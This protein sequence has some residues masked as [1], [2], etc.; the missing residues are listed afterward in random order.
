MREETVDVRDH[1]KTPPQ[2]ETH[3][4]LTV[5]SCTPRT[6]THARIHT[7]N[8]SMKKHPALQSDAHKLYSSHQTNVAADA[9]HVSLSHS[10]MFSGSRGFLCFS[11]TGCR[12]RPLFVSF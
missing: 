2:T 1:S 9:R 4:H 11:T 12:T 8:K 6:H 7:H 5:D 10:S 3:F